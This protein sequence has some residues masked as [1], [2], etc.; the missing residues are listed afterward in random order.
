MTPYIELTLINNPLKFDDSL[1]ID[2]I[3]WLYKG[4]FLYNERCYTTFAKSYIIHT[5]WIL[6]ILLKCN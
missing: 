4:E 6:S 1:L 3:T 5:F 2:S